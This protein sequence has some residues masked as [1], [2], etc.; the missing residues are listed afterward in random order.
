MTHDR[1]RRIARHVEYLAAGTLSAHDLGQFRTAEARHHD[2]GDEQVEWLC[3]LRQRGTGLGTTLKLYLPRFVGAIAENAP[4]TT[5]K[6]TENAGDKVA[7]P[8]GDNPVERP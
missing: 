1:L 5:G 7:L 8:V 6:A 3:V 4:E 2:I